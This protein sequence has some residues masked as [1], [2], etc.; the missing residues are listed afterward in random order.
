MAPCWADG[1]PPRVVDTLRL[2]L[3]DPE[4]ARR[5][6]MAMKD[7]SDEFKADAVALYESTPGAACK[8]IAADLGVNRAPLREWMLRDRER[9]GL[10]A[11][12]V[13]QGIQPRERCRLLI[14]TSGSGNWRPG[15]PSSRRVSA[16][17]PSSGTS[18]TGRRSVPAGGP[19]RW[20]GRVQRVVPG[21]RYAPLSCQAL[22]SY[23]NV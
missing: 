15:W 1:A 20:R 4:E 8:S 17:S 7:Y 5:P 16:S 19:S 6:P 3:F 23:T 13:R 18:C 9:R 22:G 21:G 10:T 12:V 14:R 2:D 11:A